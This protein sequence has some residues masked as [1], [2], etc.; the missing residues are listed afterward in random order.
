MADTAATRRDLIVIGSSAGGIPVLMDL[1]A[2]LPKDLPAAILVVQHIGSHPSILPELLSARG[3]RKAVHARAGDPLSMDVIHV[4]PPDHHLMIADDRI[5]LS[6]GPKENHARPAID[7]L[8]RSAAIAKGARVIG[9]VLSGRLDDGTAG[10]QAIKACGGLAV[11]QD[12]FDAEESS[13]PASAIANVA[14]DHVA[15]RDTLAGTLLRLVG[16]P[17]SSQPA[18][19]DALLREHRLSRGE[20]NAMEQLDDIGTPSR[21]VCPD[22]SGVLWEIR[23]S[24][25]PRYRC[26]TGHAYTLRSLE[27]QQAQRTDE[28][29]WS[30][31]RALNEREA[32]LREMALVLRREGDEAEVRRL[33]EEAAHV[34]VHAQQLQRIAT[35]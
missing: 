21:I 28:S 22:C 13:M 27:Y 3:A 29:L 6:K 26:H 20:E 19:P 2:A 16:Q 25:P 9:V 17:V 31:L 32:L 34:A 4:A 15:T 12:P 35:G 23:G 14:V 1:L 8:F 33:E 11:V 18:L 7:P 10:L 24:S 5:E 30:A